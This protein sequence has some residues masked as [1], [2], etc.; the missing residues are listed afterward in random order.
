MWA[1]SELC[2]WSA[3]PLWVGAVAATKDFVR[4]RSQREAERGTQPGLGV[5]QQGGRPL[6]AIVQ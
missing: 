3:G 1:V 6:R 4:N 5:R 2:H